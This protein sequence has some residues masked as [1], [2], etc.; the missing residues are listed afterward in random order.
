MPFVRGDISEQ[1]KPHRVLHI[2]RIEVCHVFD[3]MARYVVKDV[4]RQ[5]PV[6]IN[7]SYTA[8]GLNVLKNEIAKQGCLAGA[9]L[10]DDVE[11]MP[12]VSM[13]KSKRQ[14]LPPMFP[15]PQDTVFFALHIPKRASTP[16]RTIPECPGR[17]L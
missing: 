10:A 5:I 2:S 13:R 7:H 9:R 16:Q 8:P 11:M 17:R 14:F 1:V 3:A 6:R 12:P 15:Q 4:I